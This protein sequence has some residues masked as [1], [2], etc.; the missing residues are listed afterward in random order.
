MEPLYSL[1]L[2]GSSS[3]NSIVI[4]SLLGYTVAYMH[5]RYAAQTAQLMRT[6]EQAKEAL[7][8]FRE[9]FEQA[10]MG[11]ALVDSFSGRIHEL[12]QRFA[13]ITGRAR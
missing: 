7:A 11:I 1:K 12:N 5:H 9:L 4:F 8:R 13:E 3:D 6:Q 10:P 2:T